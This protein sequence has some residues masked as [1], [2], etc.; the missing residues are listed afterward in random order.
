MPKKKL[1]HNAEEL[2]QQAYGVEADR[3]E[4][5]VYKYTDCGAWIETRDAL[6]RMGSIVEGVDECVEVHELK[7]PFTLKTFFDALK[8]IEREAK[9]IW[10]DTHGC[11]DCNNPTDRGDGIDPKCKTCKGEGVIK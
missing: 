2:A 6:I 10:D 4:R 9:E 7:F 8:D 1:I 11:P 3:L 5:Y